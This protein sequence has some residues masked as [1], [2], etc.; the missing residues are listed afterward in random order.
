MS[1]RESTK[2]LRDGHT[3]YSLMHAGW[4]K[5]EEQFKNRFYFHVY[6]DAEVG[7]AEKQEATAKIHEAVANYDAV[8]A[9]NA[10]L[11]AALKIALPYVESF[12]GD[13]ADRQTKANAATVR[14]AIAKATESEVE[15]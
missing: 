5:S 13:N 6:A 9:Q 7:E 12:D 8:C 11:L 1:N 2:W 10:E 14:A 4:R 15:K 3:I